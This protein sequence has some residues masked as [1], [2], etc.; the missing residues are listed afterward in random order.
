M[1]AERCS[2]C[3]S[4]LG[5]NNRFCASCGQAVVDSRDRSLARLL[6]SSFAEVT[7]IDGRLWQSLRYLVLRPGFLSREYREGRRRR[8]LSPISLFLLGNLLFFLAPP[9]SDFQLS[10][11]EQYELQPYS[12]WTAQWVDA[13]LAASGRSF[14]D[15]ADAYRLRVIELAKLMVIVHVP[16]LAAGTLLIAPDQRLFYADHVVMALHYFAFLMI[17]LILVSVVFGLLYLAIPFPLPFGPYMG[18]IAILVQFLYVPAMLRTGLGISWLRA[19]LSTPLFILA[20]FITHFIY[21]LIQ[22]IVAFALVN[23]S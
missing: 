23:A 11:M 9:L 18:P 20:L 22:F 5:N 19:L 17:Y 1:G 16:L 10:L 15:V 8:Y 13:Y 7:S 14:E 3:E 6:R 12:A 21:R 2:N 4:E